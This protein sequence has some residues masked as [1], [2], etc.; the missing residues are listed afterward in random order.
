MELKF[1]N[2]FERDKDLHSADDI[3]FSQLAGTMKKLQEAESIKDFS[4][5]EN[6]RGRKVYYRFKITSGKIIYRVGIKI[7]H[8]KV[9]FLVIDTYKKRFYERI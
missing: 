7:L 5:M 6:I 9:W 3:L 2:I 1:T 8:G 4:G